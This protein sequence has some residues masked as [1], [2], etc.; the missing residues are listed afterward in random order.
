V[1]VSGG[2]SGLKNTEKHTAMYLGSGYRGPTSS[3]R[4]SLYSRAPKSGGLQQKCKRFGRESL[5]AIVWLV[6]GELA[7]PA[8]EKK[9]VVRRSA[10]CS[11]VGGSALGAE[12]G[13]VLED[14]VR[15]VL[16]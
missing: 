14:S 15:L 3:S 2:L 10:R 8:V 12:L 9:M 1:W 16:F 7:S 6:G 13:A 11:C 5:G 4:C